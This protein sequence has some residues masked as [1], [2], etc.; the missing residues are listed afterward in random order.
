MDAYVDD[1]EDYGGFHSDGARSNTSGV[2]ND[3][4][5]AAANE[6]ERRAAAEG[7]YARPDN[8]QPRGKVPDRE[9]GFNQDRRG[10]TEASTK[11]TVAGATTTTAISTETTDV[12]SMDHVRVWWNEPFGSLLQ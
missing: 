9:R 12:R 5:L 1:T 6:S 4:H 8:R 2:G 3:R 10:A 11:I 7:T